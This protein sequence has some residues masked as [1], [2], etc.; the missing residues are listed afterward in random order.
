[1]TLSLSTQL[2][3][4]DSVSSVKITGTTM[5]GTVFDVDSLVAKPA[6]AVSYTAVV[7]GA[8]GLTGSCSTWVGAATTAA[9]TRDIQ[10][11]NDLKTIQAALKSYY[12]DHST[13]MVAGSGAN[14][15]GFGFFSTAYATSSHP[16]YKSVEQQLIDQGYLPAPTRDPLQG[17]RGYLIYPCN[18]G[19]S[20]TL[21]A[22]L[23]N[24]S[25]EDFASVAKEVCP[26][27]ATGYGKNVALGQEGP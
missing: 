18:G 13:Y 3:N 2:S 15:K 9:A 1:V 14:G 4:G 10:R 12:H 23:E 5:T 16:E 11:R 22:T 6:G 21:S 26:F 8:N 27:Y 7:T 17:S 20:Y 24:P 19:Q 25:N